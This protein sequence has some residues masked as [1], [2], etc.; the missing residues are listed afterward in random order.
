M[1]PI[2]IIS[3]VLAIFGL[4]PLVIA[5]IKSRSQKAFMKKAITTTAEVTNCEMRHGI[6]GSVYYILSLQYIT[7]GN[8]K[9]F[10]GTVGSKKQEKGD[11]IVLMYLPDQ[12]TKFS[13]DFGRKTPLAII[14]TFL[15]FLTILWVCIC[16]YNL[17]YTPT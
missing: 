6:K 11:Q 16:L 3:L 14:L 4:L 2:K 1:D 7:T 15:F 9:M 10:Y 17:D 13:I 5:V 8:N 12:P